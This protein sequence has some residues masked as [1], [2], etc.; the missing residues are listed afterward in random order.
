MPNNRRQITAFRR[1]TS[2]SYIFN[3]Y[4]HPGWSRLNLRGLACSIRLALE[5]NLHW[6]HLEQVLESCLSVYVPRNSGG[7]G[8]DRFELSRAVIAVEMGKPFKVELDGECLSLV[9][10]DNMIMRVVQ[11]YIDHAKTPSFTITFTDPVEGTR[12]MEAF[13]K[14]E[15]LDFNVATW[16]QALYLKPWMS[17]HW[18]FSQ[19]SE[20]RLGDRL[21]RV[22]KPGGYFQAHGDLEC[23]RLAPLPGET[24]VVYEGGATRQLGIS[25]SPKER[26]RHPDGQVFATV[27]PFALAFCARDPYDRRSRDRVTVFEDHRLPIHPP[28]EDGDEGNRPDVD[29]YDQEPEGWYSDE[30]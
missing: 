26:I 22:Y 5:A 13:N 8:S 20:Q 27:G 19:G 16:E 15:F 1:P 2:V 17:D 4:R 12:V 10:K 11:S 25:T 3:P 30:D 9:P 18:I 28:E 6:S 29:D 14:Y 7:W 21:T 24:L 23:Y